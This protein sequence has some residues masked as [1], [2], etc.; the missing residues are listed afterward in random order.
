MINRLKERSIIELFQAHSVSRLSCPIIVFCV[1]FSHSKDDAG[2]IN[3]MALFPDLF[4]SVY[5]F[6][7]ERGWNSRESVIMDINSAS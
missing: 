2:K 3:L 4:G 7:K 1:S 5:L 6:A